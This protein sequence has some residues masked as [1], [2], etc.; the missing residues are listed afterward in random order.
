MG[1]QTPQERIETVFSQIN[2]NLMM[3]H[4]YAKQS[5]GFFTRMASKIAAMTF[6]QYVNFARQHPIE[7][8]KYALIQFNQRVYF[9]S[10]YNSF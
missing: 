3:I 7:K 5:R 2:D 9:L 4:N 8:I 6:I 10:S 1:L